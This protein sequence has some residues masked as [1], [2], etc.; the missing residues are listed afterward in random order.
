MNSRRVD[1][2]QDYWQDAWQR[3]ILMLD[4]LRQRGNIYREHNAR[5]ASP[6]SSTSRPSWCAMAGR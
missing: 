3:S 1:P 2:V 4:V 6:T 5:N